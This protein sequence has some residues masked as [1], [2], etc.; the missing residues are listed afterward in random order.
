MRCPAWGLSLP[1]A[2]TEST[3]HEPW[4][5]DSGRGMQQLEPARSKGHW[6]LVTLCH[7]AVGLTPFQLLWGWPRPQSWRWGARRGVY[8]SP[9][10]WPGCCRAMKGNLRLQ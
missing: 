6:W 1:R 3:G 5:R 8:K 9:S 2:A 7:L 4:E 10:Y